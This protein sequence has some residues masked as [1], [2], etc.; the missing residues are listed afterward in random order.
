MKA[1]LLAVAGVALLEAPPAVSSRDTLSHNVT[2][3]SST[4]STGGFQFART[5]PDAKS[6]GIASVGCTAHK[7]RCQQ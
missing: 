7:S 4:S 5:V 1:I 3:A 2:P 6:T